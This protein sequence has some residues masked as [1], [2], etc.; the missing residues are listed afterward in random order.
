LTADPSRLEALGDQAITARLAGAG[1][2][3]ADIEHV[4]AAVPAGASP[5]EFRRAIIDDNV[6]RKGTGTSRMW[7]WKRL[8]LRYALDQPETVEFAAFRRAMRDS[9]P[10]GRGLTAMLMFAR[11]DRLFRETTL[12]IL[13]PRLGRT[14]EIVPAPIIREDVEARM[15]AAGLVWSDESRAAVANH[16]ASSWK[17]FGLVEGSKVRRVTHVRPSHATVRFAVELGRAEGRT[18]RQVLDGPWFRLLGMDATG[19]EPALRSAA[20]DGVLQYR[21]Q[22]DVIEITLPT[23]PN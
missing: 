16:V 12:Q 15:Q 23:D 10:A 4:M 14:G 21:A 17:D 5:D 7:A 3:R 22:A 2:M 9:D 20:R 19:A 8:K 11:Q 1:S 6:A 13:A 18:D